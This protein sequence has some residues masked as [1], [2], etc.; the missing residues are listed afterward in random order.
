[1][2]ELVPMHEKISI[3]PIGLI[4]R[5]G[6]SFEEWSALAP[7]LGTAVKSMAFVIGDW[8]VYG[9]D[10]FTPGS[11]KATTA[12]RSQI[13]AERFELV[14]SATG[15]DAGT[16]RNYAYV[17]RRVPISLRNEALSWEHHKTVAK[18]AAPAQQH[19]LSVAASSS[20]KISSRRLRESI[21]R[22][23]LV[24]VEEMAAPP[25]EQG[26]AN[27]IPPINR[28]AAWWNQAGGEQWLRSRSPEQLAALLRD[29]RPVI[30]ILDSIESR[31]AERRA[32]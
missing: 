17:S 28:L 18:L 1:M 14:R 19:W 20:E 6:L 7:Q 4:V 3:S 24:A 23:R 32:A 12:P 11:G 5:E 10:H 15:I 31:T 27:H 30:D 13:P 25:S 21:V 9:E 16:L 8:L 22:N 26:V 29:F 2:S